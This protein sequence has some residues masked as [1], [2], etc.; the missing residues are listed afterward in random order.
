MD[1]QREALGPTADKVGRVYPTAP[2]V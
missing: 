2:E 1:K